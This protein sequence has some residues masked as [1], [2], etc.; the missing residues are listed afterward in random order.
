[1]TLAET[2]PHKVKPKVIIRRIDGIKENQLLTDLQT[3]ILPYDT[4]EPT[5]KGW[6]W[7]ARTTDGFPVAF[8]GMTRSSKWRDT[9]YLCRAGVLRE[10]RGAGLQARLIR[11]REHK[12]KELG[13]NWLVTDTYDNPASSNSLINCGFKLY[14]PSSPWGAKGTLYWKKKIHQPNRDIE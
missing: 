12:A 8:C 14:E 2:P 11:V 13:M 6:W 4:P 3:T 9:I 5:A 7:V 10:F 1:M